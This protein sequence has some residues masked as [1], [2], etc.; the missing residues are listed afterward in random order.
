LAVSRIST[1]F[2]EICFSCSRTQCSQ[3]RISGRGMPGAFNDAYSYDPLATSS[4]TQVRLGHH[5][6]PRNEAVDVAVKNGATFGASSEQLVPPDSYFSCLYVHPLFGALS[7]WAANASPLPPISSTRGAKV[8]PSDRRATRI[9]WGEPYSPAWGVGLQ[10]GSGASH[11]GSTQKAR[12]VEGKLRFPAS[13]N[14]Y[15]SPPKPIP[16]MA[17]LRA[18]T[19]YVHPSTHRYAAAPHGCHD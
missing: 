7:P 17:K 4:T 16:K 9:S 18:L 10:P 12:M 8:A 1:F 11:L 3:R 13:S 2:R 6:Y 19:T 14:P 5:P 15:C